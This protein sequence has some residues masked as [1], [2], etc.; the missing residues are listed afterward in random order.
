[1]PKHRFDSKNSNGLFILSD[2]NLCWYSLRSNI[3]MQ[4]YVFI[5]NYNIAQEIIFYIILI[6]R[7]NRGPFQTLSHSSESSRVY[8]TLYI[9]YIQRE[10]EVT[11][12]SVI[13]VDICA[14]L[15]KGRSHSLHNVSSHHTATTST[16]K[17]YKLEDFNLALDV[18]FNS[19]DFQFSR[20]SICLHCSSPHWLW[21]S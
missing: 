18:S 8:K 7:K 20:D 19:E 5:W 13:C 15:T 21:T 11:L 17:I 1:M 2:V 4:T 10:A 12:K 9:A 3:S 16:F 14:C 6:R